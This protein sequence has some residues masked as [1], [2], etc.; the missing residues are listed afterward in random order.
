MKLFLI[1]LLV[2]SCKK[3]NQFTGVDYQGKAKSCSPSENKVCT[4]I[5]TP[6]D[7]YA[8]DCKDQGKKAIQCDCHDWICVK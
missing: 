6:S 2:F 1:F 7:Q 4:E 8:L 3:S 5:F